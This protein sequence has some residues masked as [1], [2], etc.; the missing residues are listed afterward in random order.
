MSASRFRLA[1]KRARTAEDGDIERD[2]GFSESAGGGRPRRLGDKIAQSRGGFRIGFP[3]E[4]QN[5]LRGIRLASQSAK[6][7]RAAR[8]SKQTREPLVID[9]TAFG[10]KV[11]Q[12]LAEL[13]H[14]G[15]TARDRNPRDRVLPQI[16]KHA[17]DEVTHFDQGCVR[18]SMHALDGGLR[19]GAGCACDV[20]DSTG[21]GDVDATANTARSVTNAACPLMRLGMSISSE[22]QKC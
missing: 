1:H 22:N 6:F 14:F 20:L 2:A 9:T 19:R 10:V 5:M 8:I 13:G 15:E 16:F 18:Q 11:E 4:F 3:G 17:A 21:A 12:S 7:D